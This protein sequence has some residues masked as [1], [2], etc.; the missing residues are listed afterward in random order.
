M[1]INE[2]INI[3]FIYNSKNLCKY[4][5]E[6]KKLIDFIKIEI[7]K[8]NGKG[9]YLQIKLVD[10]NNKDGLTSLK[11]KNIVE[12]PVLFINNTNRLTSAVGVK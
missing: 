8:I 2:E 9:K 7:N 11:N 12:F 5:K 3:F 4:N 6:T 1:N 10:E